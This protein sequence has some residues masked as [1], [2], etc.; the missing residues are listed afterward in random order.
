MI[1]FSYQ[2]L[3]EEFCHRLSLSRI[4]WHSSGKPTEPGHFR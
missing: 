2:A 3:K 4:S 1:T